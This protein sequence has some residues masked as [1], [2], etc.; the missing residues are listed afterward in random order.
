M[1]IIDSLSGPPYSGRFLHIW[2]KFR[3]WIEQS[4]PASLLETCP[5]S[6]GSFK[7][8]TNQINY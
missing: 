1:E 6:V 5:T 3:S 7:S 2:N 4:E 8:K